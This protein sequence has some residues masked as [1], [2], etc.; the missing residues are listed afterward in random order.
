M[1]QSLAG[2][3]LSEGE[4]EKGLYLCK[5]VSIISKI[6]VDGKNKNEEIDLDNHFK[7]F[8]LFFF[9]GSKLRSVKSSS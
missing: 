1:T 4:N 2:E 6:L 9:S 3:G 5:R 8:L 7:F